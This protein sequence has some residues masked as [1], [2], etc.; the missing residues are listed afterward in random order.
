MLYF[1]QYKMTLIENWISTKDNLREVNWIKDLNEKELKSLRLDSFYT[2]DEEKITWNVDTAKTYLQSIKDK[3]EKRYGATSIMAIQILLESKGYEI[4][5]IDGYRWDKT[6]KALK[7][8]EENTYGQWDGLLWEKTINAL[9]YKNLEDFIA[10]IKNSIKNRTPEFEEGSKTWL[11]FDEGYNWYIE[12]YKK[13]P[14]YSKIESQKLFSDKEIQE[15]KE[16]YYDTLADTI[17]K[18]SN[19]MEDRVLQTYK[20]VIEDFDE[21][22]DNNSNAYKKLMQWYRNYRER[23]R[24]RES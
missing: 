23:W 18:A 6:K 5:K 9:L 12:Y 3:P 4:E 24:N 19:T 1:I 16:K 21:E 8:L 17:I 15:I 22:T 20:N 10:E 13:N 14:L 11:S 2:I 7:L